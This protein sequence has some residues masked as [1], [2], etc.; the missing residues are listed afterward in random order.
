MT[1]PGSTI[2]ESPTAGY[3]PQTRI[4]ISTLVPAHP[5]PYTQGTD[6]REV[7]L[8]PLK[9]MI[10]VF[11]TF[12]LCQ[13]SIS[14]T[15][16]QDFRCFYPSCSYRCQPMGFYLIPLPALGIDKKWTAACWP[17]VDL[18]HHCNV[19]IASP[20]RISAYSGFFWKPYSSFSSKNEVFFG[21]QKK[22]IHYL[23]EDGIILSHPH[24]HDGSLYYH[25]TLL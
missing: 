4:L 21:E 17:H 20:C 6:L 14:C 22:R 13:Q 16:D 15:P 3:I 24:A 11:W 7:I 12:V 19:K 18:W 10:W 5:G 9:G 25:M 8:L 2:Q 1:V 23:C